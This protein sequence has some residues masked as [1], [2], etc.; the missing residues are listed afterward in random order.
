MIKRFGTPL[1][2]FAAIAV[3]LIIFFA[4]YFA[5]NDQGKTEGVALGKAEER[6][7]SDLRVKRIQDQFDSL[8]KDSPP[9]PI[10]DEQMTA[11]MVM[12]MLDN[13]DRIEVNL[14]ITQDGYRQGVISVYF[15]APEAGK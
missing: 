14:T 12:G 5:G 10:R 11:D 13:A 7:W 8:L 2:V 6:V 4:G 9:E 1:K 15:D 3:F